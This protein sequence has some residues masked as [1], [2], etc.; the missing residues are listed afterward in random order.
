MFLIASLSTWLFAGILSIYHWKTRR[1]E[2][3]LAVL[4]GIFGLYQFTAYQIF[5]NKSAFWTAVFYAHFAPVYY[6]SGPLIWIYTRLSLSDQHKI[7]FKPKDAWHLLPFVLDCLLSIPYY[8]KSFNLKIAFSEQLILYGP[9]LMTSARHQFLQNNVWVYVSRTVVMCV[10][11]FWGVRAVVKQ[12]SKN[13]AFEWL[14]QKKTTWVLF[15]NSGVLL[16]GAFYLLFLSEVSLG[17]FDLDKFKDYKSFL[18][19]FGFYFILILSICTA[20]PFVLYNLQIQKNNPL[21]PL[22]ST[23]EI[24]N[25]SLES[26]NVQPLSDEELMRFI[27][28]ENNYVLSNFNIETVSFQTNRPIKEILNVVKAETG[29]SFVDYKIHLRVEMAKR[30][31]LSDAVKLNSI[32]GIGKMSGF[33][34]KS[35]F[36]G[37]F[38][39]YERLTPKEFLILQK[40]PREKQPL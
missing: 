21:A 16:I 22:E 37:T 12:I 17:E 29:L 40:L 30:L 2:L 14:E 36:Y 9:E 18:L 19:S 31:L 32:D 5:E 26:K 25:E 4:F 15:F 7:H 1:P 6:L 13:Q 38:K 39:R 35:H 28:N 20:F 3:L 11:A 8:Q 24:A 34:T 23:A 27:E 33:N 10:Y